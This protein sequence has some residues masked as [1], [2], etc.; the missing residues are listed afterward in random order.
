MFPQWKIYE[1]VTNIVALYF[2][3]LLIENPSRKRHLVA[4]T[5]VGMAAFF[6]RNHGV[7]C[8]AAFLLLIL[9]IRWR[10]DRGSLPVRV[11]AWGLGIVIGYAP[12]LFMF[13]FVPGFF[14]ACVEVFTS[15]LRVKYRA[16]QIGRERNQRACDQ[17][18]ARNEVVSRRVNSTVRLLLFKS[19]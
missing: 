7:Y 13:A 16:E 5:F 17:Q 3:T 6:G 9:F 19:A 18:L 4:G 2:A 11:G 12:M 8:F 14:G 15:N 10:I 1:H